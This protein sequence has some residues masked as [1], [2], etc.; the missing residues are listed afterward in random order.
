M[1]PKSLIRI[2]E[3]GDIT[4]DGGQSAKI[5]MLDAK[6]PDSFHK[7]VQT[8]VYRVMAYTGK[9]NRYGFSQVGMTKYL[10]QRAPIQVV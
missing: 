1:I 8:I 6:W 10:L 3:Q 7:D 9:A 5:T 2:S 4:Y